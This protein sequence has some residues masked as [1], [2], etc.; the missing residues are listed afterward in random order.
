[1]THVEVRFGDCE[2]SVERIELRR[3]D[4]LVNLEPPVFEVLAYLLRHHEQVVPKTE[5]LD[6]VWGNR[7]VSE[8]ALDQP[9]Q[10]RPPRCRP[11]RLLW[12]I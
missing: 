12:T 6:Q 11:P 9:D 4:Q 1:M 3:A 8:S 7:V 5:L 2:L 10:V